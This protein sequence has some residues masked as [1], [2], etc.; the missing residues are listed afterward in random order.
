MVF[1]PLSPSASHLFPVIQKL[2]TTK[3]LLM[4]AWCLNF[5]RTKWEC[6]WCLS[7]VFPSEANG[8]IYVM[9]STMSNIKEVLNKRGNE[10]KDQLGLVT[11]E[12]LLPQWS[13]STKRES[14][15]W[16]FES[17]PWSVWKSFL[18]QLL[19]PYHYNNP[20]FM[21]KD[22]ISSKSGILIWLCPYLE[23]CPWRFSLNICLSSS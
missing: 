17:F 18:I 4:L 3:V 12:M 1:V 16:C 7:Q 21:T 20:H 15:M 14:A 6:S 5:L 8:I 2:H 11:W 10:N 9:L 13:P 22:S 19:L 23:V